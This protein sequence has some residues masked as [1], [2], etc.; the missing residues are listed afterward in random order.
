M[1]G[2]PYEEK[3]VENRCF[4]LFKIELKPYYMKALGEH[5]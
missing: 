3:T 2:R 5:F 1:F 4:D